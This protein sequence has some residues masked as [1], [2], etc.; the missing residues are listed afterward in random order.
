M[1]SS[2]V[3]VVV[4]L[5]VLLEMPR[6]VDGEDIAVSCVVVE[7]IT[8]YIIGRLLRWEEKDGASFGVCIIGSS[9]NKSAPY[10]LWG[11]D[12]CTIVSS[13]IEASGVYN[14]ART[15]DLM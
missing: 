2:L 5:N 15:F 1:D 13:N 6:L 9:Y 10:G 12:I 11:N 8:I 7:G 3:A 4:V 14:F